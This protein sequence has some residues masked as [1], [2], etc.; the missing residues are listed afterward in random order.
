MDKNEEGKNI[1]L[2]TGLISSALVFMI[3]TGYYVVQN[4]ENSSSSDMAVDQR[5]DKCYEE[6]GLE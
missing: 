6:K 4:T 2:T 3:V 1:F 5:I